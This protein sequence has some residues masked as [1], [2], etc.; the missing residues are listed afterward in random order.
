MSLSAQSSAAAATLKERKEAADPFILVLVSLLSLGRMVD[1]LP[2]IDRH[3]AATLTCTTRPTTESLCGDINYTCHR[4]V[5]TFLH[6]SYTIVTLYR[7]VTLEI[8]LNRFL[9]YQSSI[10][11]AALTLKASLVLAAGESLASSVRNLV[12]AQGC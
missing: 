8:H 1:S 6:Q 5:L 9:F 11:Q 12:L 7:M 2:R 4:Q 10:R 3:C